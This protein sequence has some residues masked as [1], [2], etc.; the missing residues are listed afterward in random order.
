MAKAAYLTHSTL[1]SLLRF[2]FLAFINFYILLYKALSISGLGFTS[3]LFIQLL[4]FWVMELVWHT[5]LKYALTWQF[6][7]TLSTFSSNLNEARLYFL[8]KPMTLFTSPGL[9]ECT[10]NTQLEDAKFIF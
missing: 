2:G 9:D 6:F 1:A 3:G 10:I 5:G 4:L 7:K 8:R